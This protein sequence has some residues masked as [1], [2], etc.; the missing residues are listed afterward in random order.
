MQEAELAGEAAF[1]GQASEARR[2]AEGA[3]GVV[4]E[5]ESGGTA[6]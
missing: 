4:I 5:V 1:I 2:Y 3:Y 6:R